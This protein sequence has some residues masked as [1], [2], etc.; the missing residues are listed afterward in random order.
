MRAAALL[1]LFAASLAH[2]QIY[3]W[4]DEQGRARYGERPPPGAKARLVA[5]PSQGAAPAE[6]PA[7][8]SLDA[9]E[10]DFRRRQIERREAEERQ[11]AATRMRAEH[12]DGLRGQL[13][14]AGQARLFRVE[15]GERVYYSD[16]EREAHAERLRSLIRERC[17]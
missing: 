15:K 17:P 2:G 12:C 1:L 8:R 7:G 3:R 14:L 13:A 6:R 10:T 4:T 11:A 9:Q 5:P 16:A